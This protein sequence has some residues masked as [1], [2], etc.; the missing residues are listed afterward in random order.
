MELTIKTPDEL[1]KFVIRNDISVENAVKITDKRLYI[2]D[3]T[4][5]KGQKL[6]EYLKCLIK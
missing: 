3:G 4:I 5:K 2:Y 6:S 1:M